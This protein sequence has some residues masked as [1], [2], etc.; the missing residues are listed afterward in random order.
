MESGDVGYAITYVNGSLTVNTAPLTI[1][2]DDQTKIFGE[3]NPAFTATYSGFVLGQGSGVLGGTLTFNTTATAGSP[4][5]T[6]A[7]TPGGLISG[8]YA[9]TF[10]GGTLT[11]LSDAQATA[12]LQARVDGA[13]LP[14][15]VQNSLDS[16]L[17]A[18]IDSFNRGRTNAAVNQLNAFINSVKAQRGKQIDAA[19][20]DALSACALRIINAVGMF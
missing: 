5:G 3:A 14:R 2:A 9:I 16:K 10:V 17:Q 11:V 18:A 1:T 4:P 20:A 7:I 8:N 6:Y 13:N 15:G 19:L 12:R